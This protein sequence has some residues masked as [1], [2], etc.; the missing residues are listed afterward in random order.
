VSIVRQIKAMF[1]QAIAKIKEYIGAKGII[2]IAILLYCA[3]P[4]YDARNQWWKLRIPFIVHNLR[5]LLMLA[6]FAVMWLDLRN[7]SKKRVA[8]R[9]GDLHSLQGRTLKLRDD[10]KEYCESL[11]PVP[12]IQWDSSMRTDP[13]KFNQ[14]NMPIF[15][16]ELQLSHGYEL[17]FAEDVIRIYHEF[18]E[19]GAQHP[20]L[21]DIIHRASEKDDA[22]IK[23]VVDALSELA[24][25]PEAKN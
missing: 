9:Y 10:I 15:S 22:S 18:G 21:R 6:A 3:L 12:D 20:Q 11:G 1:R 17:R 14:V 13:V 23:I 19:R 25:R 5:W 8:G 2:G 24:E 7:I 4:D 16:R